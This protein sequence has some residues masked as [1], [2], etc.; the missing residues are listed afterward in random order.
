MVLD[1][2]AFAL[3]ALKHATAV[4]LHFLDRA[5]VALCVVI[6]TLVGP[7]EEMAESAQSYGQE[8]TSTKRAALLSGA[9]RMLQMVYELHCHLSGKVPSTTLEELERAMAALFAHSSLQIT[10]AP[11]MTSVTID[12]PSEFL[13]SGADAVL[14]MPSSSV[15]QFPLSDLT[16]GVSDISLMRTTCLCKWGQLKLPRTELGKRTKGYFVLVNAERAASVSCSASDPS[17]AVVAEASV[18]SAGLSAHDRAAVEVAMQAMLSTLTG[19][20]SLADA[21]QPCGS[22]IEDNATKMVRLV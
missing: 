16:P 13:T 18:A 8:H 12:A 6:C 3:S 1:V 14:D 5:A 9:D 10:R 19:K 21:A 11:P 17:T 2:T 15:S 20:R 4:V 7:G 22:E